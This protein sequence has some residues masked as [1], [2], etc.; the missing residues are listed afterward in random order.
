DELLGQI[1]ETR[2]F[3]KPQ[4]QGK[5][6]QVNRYVAGL[7]ATLLARALGLGGTCYT[8]DGSCASSLYSL[9]YAVAELQA[10]RADAMLCGGLS[11][12]DSLYTQMG[13]STLG[14]ISASGRCSPFD[15]KAHGL[16]VG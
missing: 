4:Q 7:P 16:V 1:F 9:K 12:P 15:S 10:G 14:A 11:R 2:L 6:S 5:T 3:G 13:F 8:L